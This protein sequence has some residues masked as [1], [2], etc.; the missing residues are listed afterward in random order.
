MTRQLKIAAFGFAAFIAASTSTFD[1]PLW[2]EENPPA[3]AKV[4]AEYCLSAV[5]EGCLDNPSDRRALATF[6]RLDLGNGIYEDTYEFRGVHPETGEPI[7]YLERVRNYKGLIPIRVTIR[8]R[9]STRMSDRQG[10]EPDRLG[11]LY[12]DDY[13][14]GYDL[15]DLAEPFTRF[16]NGEEVRLF[17]KMAFSWHES[18][19]C[20]ATGPCSEAVNTGGPKMMAWPAVSSIGER[21]VLVGKETV[22][23]PDGP[24]KTLIV[25]YLH[26]YLFIWYDPVS[27][28]VIQ[29]KIIDRTGA[30]K[31]HILRRR[32]RVVPQ[33]PPQ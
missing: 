19:F 6:S 15:A 10:V 29:T 8:E 14:Y 12:I 7:E 21:W 1:A 33:E 18:Y 4:M 24:I 28:Q 22:E 25:E 31:Y 26:A 20:N 32:I 11:H 13:N 27:E 17:Y 16:L 3:K 30:K 9:D 2:A 5:W 23:T